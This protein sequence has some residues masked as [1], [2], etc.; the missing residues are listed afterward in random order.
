MELLV[1]LGM[2][3]AFIAFGILKASKEDE[4]NGFC[5]LD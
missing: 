3:A 4:Q 2:I 1:G 5:R